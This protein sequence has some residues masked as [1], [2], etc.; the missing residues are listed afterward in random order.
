VVAAVILCMPLWSIVIAT[1]IA[2]D[3]SAI[4]AK[5]TELVRMCMHNHNPVL[6]YLT[7]FMGLG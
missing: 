2:R 7:L 5:Q 1:R 3:V 6:V 4:M